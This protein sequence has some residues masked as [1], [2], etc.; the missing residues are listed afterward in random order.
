MTFNDEESEED[1]V[2]FDSLIDDSEDTVELIEAEDYK[3]EELS[4]DEEVSLEVNGV[5]AESTKQ[6]EVLDGEILPPDID[7]NVSSSTESV[8]IVVDDSEE[9]VD[10]TNEVLEHLKKLATERLKPVSKSLDIS[11][12]TVLKKPTA[13]IQTLQNQQVKVAKWIL[14]GQ[15]SI[16]LMKEFL[17]SELETL[18]EFS[19][20]NTSLAML[21]R[22]YK[23]IYDH[24]A[25]AKP[26]S[27]ETWLKSTP[28]SDIDHYFFAVYIAS[29]KGANF[30]PM[31]C[32]DQDKCKESFLTDDIDIMRMVKFETEEDKTKFTELY[33]NEQ[34][35]TGKGI[36][37]TEI[38]P[39]SNSIAVAFKEPSIYSLFEI[40]SLDQRFK[41]K[42]TSILEFIPYIDS[43]YIIDIDNQQLTPV[44]YKVYEENAQKTVKSKV[45]QFE[46]VLK[47]L[48]VDEFGPIKA[49]IKAIAER[50]SGI[51]YIYPSVTCPKCNK[52]TE[53]RRTSA[54]ELVFTRYQLGTLVNTSLK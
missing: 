43:L 45:Q 49:Y 39:L 53:E 15:E 4:V 33:K 40:A 36:Y 47:T 50:R 7:V 2:S 3:V 17:G 23:M 10:D 51:G 11:S 16:V 26:A 9:V 19:E 44:G 29:F 52:S 25:S 42:H 41:D 22:R 37:Y 54:E 24:I 6:D 32:T 18:R 34:A 12:F 8:E 28:F 13:K 48:S 30:L 46:N 27:Y 35:P 14:P 5:K 21:S 20:D 1:E 31:D 38:I